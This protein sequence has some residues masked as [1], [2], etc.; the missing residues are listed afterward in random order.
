MLETTGEAGGCSAVVISTLRERRCKECS[1]AEAATGRESELLEQNSS[2]GVLLNH[3]SQRG[4]HAATR[5]GS[6]S[7][8]G[9]LRDEYG[10]CERST[11]SRLE[12]V[13]CEF[14]AAD[15][16]S[17]RKGH[18][19][20]DVAEGSG[21]E[22]SDLGA[23]DGDQGKNCNMESA[24]VEH[25]GSEASSFERAFAYRQR[26]LAELEPVMQ[27]VLDRVHCLKV[28]ICTQEQVLEMYGLRYKGLRR[29]C[30]I[31]ACFSKPHRHQN[32]SETAFVAYGKYSNA[33]CGCLSMVHIPLSILDQCMFLDMQEVHLASLVHLQELRLPRIAT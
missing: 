22:H 33:S 4:G 7:Q 19:I 24:D 9:D 6:A 8:L 31:S 21:G 12:G 3:H 20:G 27:G 1:H 17:L 14:G 10:I 26:V 15:G 11:S 32:C 28:C 16:G 13:C 30:I 18:K 2:C 5:A 29:T 23:A 25:G